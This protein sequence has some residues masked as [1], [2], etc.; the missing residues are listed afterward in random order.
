MGNK[1]RAG[2]GERGF[3]LVELAIVLTI[4]GLLIG[5]VLK[6]MELMDNARATATVAQIK[7]YEAAFLSFNDMY[8][9]HPGDMY[10]AAN[11]LVGCTIGCTP[12]TAS[13]GNRI[14]GDPVWQTAWQS[15]GTATLGAVAST[16][17]SQETYLFWT[18]LMLANLI[19]GVTADGILRPVTYTWGQTHPASKL[20]GGFIV[21]YAGVTAGGAGSA[22]GNSGRNCGNGNNAGNNGNCRG[23]GTGGAQIGVGTVLVMLPTPTTDPTATTTG[24][25]LLTPIMAARL[26]RKI[27]DGMPDTGIVLAFG[28]LT[29]YSNRLGAG[30]YD[31]SVTTKDCGILYSTGH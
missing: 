8:H 19:G 29:C 13:S 22:P 16:S 14:V 7:S 11:R 10:G 18:H 17:F 1:N 27:D 23:S 21:G 26:D 9:A 20:G 24:S 2:T 5:G 31:E 25:Q 30:G 28:A 15:Q 3:T 6:G 12:F 4:I